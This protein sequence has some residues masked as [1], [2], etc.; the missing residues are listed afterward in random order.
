MIWTVMWDIRN[1]RIM[2]YNYYLYDSKW[3]VT[4]ANLLA[5][6]HKMSHSPEPEAYNATGLFL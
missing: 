4:Q 5:Q 3:H 2:H 6:A 1:C